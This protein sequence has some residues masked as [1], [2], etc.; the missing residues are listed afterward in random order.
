MKSSTVRNTERAQDIV[1]PL[2]FHRAAIIC[3]S[4]FFQNIQAGQTLKT[5][6][7][8]PF[9]F[10]TNTF[11]FYFLVLRSLT[12]KKDISNYFLTCSIFCRNIFL[13]DVSHNL[14]LTVAFSTIKWKAPN[15]GNYIFFHASKLPR[16]GGDSE[17]KE[18]LE[19]IAKCQIVHNF[20]ISVSLPGKHKHITW[21]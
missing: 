20:T 16:L 4:H 8:V 5:P 3:S 17:E 6:L 11:F 10:I 21:K 19:W 18:T 15:V 14:L 7:L 1:I 9:S 12:L 13:G 2:S